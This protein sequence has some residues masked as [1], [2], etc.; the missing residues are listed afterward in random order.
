MAQLITVNGKYSNK[1]VVSNTIRYITRTR[2]DED[3]RNELIVCG[4]PNVTC[5]PDEEEIFRA[6]KEFMDI[7]HFYHD[8]VNG[9][10]VF[11][12]T[13]NLLHEESEYFYTRGQ[14]NALALECSRI[15]DRQ[16]FQVVYAAHYSAKYRLHIHFIVNA[17]SY[18]DGK[19]YHSD[20]KD[21]AERNAEFN[22]ILFRHIENNKRWMNVIGCYYPN[23]NYP[24]FYPNIVIGGLAAYGQ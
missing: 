2:P 17:V 14:I 22:E 7:Q 9:R 24:L 20:Y 4:S 15:Y 11:H 8:V 10:R 23:L 1:N 5:I 3:R 19:K 21:H 13:F 16:G 18:C 12:E 6:I